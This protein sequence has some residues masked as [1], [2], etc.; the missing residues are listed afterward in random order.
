MITFKQF[1]S[2]KAMNS[3][4]FNKVAS[5]HAVT[6]K[7]EFECFIPEQSSLLGSTEINRD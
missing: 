2:E 6:A 4:E 7:V 1:I 5:K 3:R